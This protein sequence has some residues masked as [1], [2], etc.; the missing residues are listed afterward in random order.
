MAEIRR[1]LVEGKVVYPIIYR[2]LHPSWCKISSINSMESWFSYVFPLRR[3][4]NSG[5]SC[6]QFWSLVRK[7]PEN[8]R[9]LKRGDM[10]KGKDP[11][12]ATTF[13]GAVRSFS[14]VVAPWK[15]NLDPQK[16]L[17]NAWTQK[18]M[19]NWYHL[20][21]AYRGKSWVWPLPSNSDHQDHSIFSRESLYIYI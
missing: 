5:N 13:S 7:K 10:S 1:S 15:I 2:V 8:L 6:G 4:G 14:G 9:P 3:S 11:L 16:M 12:P 17:E 19:P 18:G 21:F 20:Q